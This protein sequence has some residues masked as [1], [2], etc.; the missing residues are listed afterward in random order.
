MRFLYLSS[1]YIRH[2]S[3]NY[4]QKT[5]AFYKSRTYIL[6]SPL[7]SNNYI[8]EYVGSLFLIDYSNRMT[9]LLD[10]MPNDFLSNDLDNDEAINGRHLNPTD[11]SLASDLP[12][13]DPL[14]EEG[15]DPIMKAGGFEG[16]IMN[17]TKIDI[18]EMRM[19]SANGRNAIRNKNGLWRNDEVPYV[20][21]NQYNS[22]E[23]GIIAK[24]FAEYHRE[25]CIK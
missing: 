7:I 22:Y 19:S 9:E 6:F 4:R 13:L 16:D 21:S 17:V 24:A 12:Q 1:C 15:E 8:Q 20:I 10:E 23:R 14:D 11:F 25:T 18:A 3:I 2:W 5:F